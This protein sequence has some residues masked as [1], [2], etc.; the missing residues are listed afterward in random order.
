MRWC[1]Q[2]IREGLSLFS[3]EEVRAQ[4]VLL[5]EE[6]ASPLAISPISM[7][8]FSLTR[9]SNLS[10]MY[11]IL[12]LSAAAASCSADGVAPSA[13][14]VRRRVHPPPPEERWPEKRETGLGMPSSSSARSR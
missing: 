5:D 11:F 7:P 9:L 8:Y 1:R 12:A 13:P 10:T 6:E 3:P 2:S 14:A 4:T